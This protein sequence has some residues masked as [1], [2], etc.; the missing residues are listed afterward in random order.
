MPAPKALESLFISLFLSHSI[1][2]IKNFYPQHISRIL[3]FLT[4]YNATQAT[5]ISHLDYGSSLLIGSLVVLSAPYIP[6]SQSIQ[7]DH[8]IPLPKILQRPGRVWLSKPCMIWPLVTT[9]SS[10]SSVSPHGAPC[11]Q[12]CPAQNLC[13]HCSVRKIISPRNLAGSV[14]LFIQVSAQTLIQTRGRL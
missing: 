6:F 5:T 11:C 8:G 7:N 10:P 3:P 13:T 4:Y 9:I 2:T 12:A 1:P 14:P